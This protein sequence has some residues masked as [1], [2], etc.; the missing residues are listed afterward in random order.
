MSIFNTYKLFK[1]YNFIKKTPLIFNERLSNKY[2]CN[3]FFKREDLQTTRSFKIRGSLNKI[4]NIIH[5]NNNKYNY[6]YNN[7]NISTAS[8]GNHA[9]GVAYVCNN[10]DLNC[11]IY[12]P[13]NTPKQKENVIKCYKNVNLIKYGK[14]FD[15]S[16]KYCLENIHNHNKHYI[17]HFL[18]PFDNNNNYFIHPFDDQYIIN[19]QGTIYY[20]IINKINPDIICSTIGGGGLLSGIISANNEYYKNKIDFI[21]CE[22]YYASSMFDSI[23][24]NKIITNENI[25]TFVDGASVKKVG[26]LTFNI[27]N[28]NITK[29]FKI[30]NKEICKKN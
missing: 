20:E 26:D 15:D 14:S 1:N 28:N 7:I 4:I 5:N 23:Y 17:H 9:Q 8:A 27:I 6:N 29:I 16:L 10:F 11:N 22:P 3:I 12:I 21:G 18:H 25:D 24:K 30:K 13:E 2:N 19:G